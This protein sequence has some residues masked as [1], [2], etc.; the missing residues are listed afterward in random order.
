MKP[1]FID[2]PGPKIDRIDEMLS[3]AGSFEL[4]I[5][6]CECRAP[7]RSY[8]YSSRY[9]T[10]VGK[11]TPCPCTIS[12]CA[13]DAFERLQVQQ[14]SQAG[15]ITK[16]ESAIEEI[17]LSLAPPREN[18]ADLA[19]PSSPESTNF[20]SVHAEVHKWLSNRV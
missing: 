10:C 20:V 1:C 19:N 13:A 11:D 3:N 9:R 4:K 5:P 7:S 14:V 2:L 18:T 6:G 12:P 15:N 16:L 8:Y 17:K